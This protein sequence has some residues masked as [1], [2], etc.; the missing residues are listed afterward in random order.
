M[1]NIV[2][3]VVVL[4]IPLI[5]MAQETKERSENWLIYKKANSG[6]PDDAVQCIKIDKSGNKWIGT[7]SGGLV[8]FDGATWK[9]FNTSNSNIPWNNVT[10]IDIDA[11]GII[12]IGTWGQGIAK[13]NGANWTNY[14]SSGDYITSIM[15]DENQN[16][17]YGTFQSGLYKFDGTNFTWIDPNT[18]GLGFYINSIS[19]DGNYNKWIG[20]TFGIGKFDNVTWTIYNPTN[21]GLPDYDVRCI[22]P[23]KNGTLWIGT[24]NESLVKYD[25]VNWFNYNPNN[26][27]VQGWTVLCTAVGETGV[28]YIGDYYQG[29]T[30]YDGT[31]W[32]T[33]N[34]YTS[35]IPG[36]WLTC[37]TI[38]KYG[39]KWIG[40]MGGIAVYNENG[41]SYSIDEQFPSN[42]KIKLFPNPTDNII[43]VEYCLPINRTEN[44]SLSIYNMLGD[45]IYSTALI[46]PLLHIDVSSFPIGAYYVKIKSV[47]G[48]AYCKFIKK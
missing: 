15:V 2:F 38:D 25:G 36:E 47:K 42:E 16:I 24:W 32:T 8:K 29:L 48:T 34:T 3:C 31:N 40:I 37:I 9:V 35:P 27:G 11:N 5:G 41:I 4:M 12:W 20:G 45:V 28:V 46:N 30:V 10:C 23:D 14:G 33:Y 7:E 13:F 22:T 43:N 1:K 18:T 17:W 19:M 26:S 21:S 39:N 44:V 6:L